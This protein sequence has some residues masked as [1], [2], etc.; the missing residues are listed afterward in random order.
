MGIETGI[1]YPDST[2]NPVDGCDGCELWNKKMGGTCYAAGIHKRFH[3]SGKG[4]AYPSPFHKV[5]MRPGRMEKAAKWSNLL[6]TDRLGSPERNIPAKPWLNG[7]KR[8]I[9]I[10]DMADIFSQAV[11]FQYLWEEVICNIESMNGS[12]HFWMVLTK[13][14]K[15]MDE[16]VLW[17]NSRGFKVPHNLMMMTSV[18]SN[19]TLMRLRVLQRINAPWRGV[20]FE[21]MLGQCQIQP[22]D[23]EGIGWVVVGG[24]SGPKSRPMHPAWVRWIRDCCADVKVPFFFKQWGSYVPGIRTRHENEHGKYGRYSYQNGVKSPNFDLDWGAGVVSIKMDK[25]A[26]GRLLDKKEYNGMPVGVQTEIG[27]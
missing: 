14:P 13:R 18:T 12:Q 24:E 17:L 11:D 10:G 4:K 23:L 20:S 3:G 15:R 16:F 8:F 25:H 9:F 26:C 27:Q 19:E 6:G 21:P 2:A 1:E 22:R 5:M 7:M